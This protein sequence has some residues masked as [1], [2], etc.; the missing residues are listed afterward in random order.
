[1]QERFA[2]ARQAAHNGAHTVHAGRRS[3]S[4][5][6]SSGTTIASGSA[7]ARPIT[8]ST[9]AGRWSRCSTSS[10][11]DLPGVCAGPRLRSAR[12][13]VPH[14]PRHAVQRRQAAAQD[15]RRRALSVEEVPEG[16]R[17]GTVRRDRAAVGLDWR[18][19]L[20]AVVERADTR[21]AP[22]IADDHRRFHRVVTAPAFRRAVGELAGDQLT[23][24]PRGYLKDHPAAEYL[25]H[26]QF[27]GG[28][29]Y[30][31]DFARQPAVLSGAA[32]GVP[33]HCAARRLPQQR[34][35]R[36]G[37]TT[38]ANSPARSRDNRGMRHAPADEY[39]ARLSARRAT[40]ATAVARRR[41]IQLRASGGVCGDA[42]FSCVA[43]WRGWLRAMVD[44][45]S[46]ASRSS[47]SS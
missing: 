24:V 1:M 27:I 42:P 44:R 33:R 38:P 5:G 32:R 35:H 29:E 40:H 45:A 34:H 37:P 13:P 36:P 16:R 46:R 39:R 14:L 43:A 21:F 2:A 31:A 10:R 9:S 28:R 25:R 30:P 15:Q 47:C 22:A 23:R 4:C 7:R 3:R 17:R 12:L 11:A 41:A 20:H 18:R 19:H 6:R 26:K 8:S